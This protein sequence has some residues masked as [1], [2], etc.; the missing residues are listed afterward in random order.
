MGW[1]SGSKE[2]KRASMTWVKWT[3]GNNK[4]VPTLSRSLTRLFIT[5]NKMGFIRLPDLVRNIQQI[6][7]AWNRSGYCT[8]VKGWWNAIR[9]YS[10]PTI[11]RVFSFISILWLSGSEW[12]VKIVMG[13]KGVEPSTF[14]LSVERSTKLSYRPRNYYS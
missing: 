6:L 10:M 5:L 8:I 13:R 14:R 4:P 12:T 9:D 3:S 2:K 11:K 1:W 7:V